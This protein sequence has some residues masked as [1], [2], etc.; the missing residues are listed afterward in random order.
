MVSRG[1]SAL[2]SHSAVWDESEINSLLNLPQ[3]MIHNY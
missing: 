3:G 1:C 2:D